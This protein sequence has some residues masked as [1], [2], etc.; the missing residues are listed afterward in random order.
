M[1]EGKGN[2]DENHCILLNQALWAAASDMDVDPNHDQVQ[3]KV[4]VI[5]ERHKSEQNFPPATRLE[6]Y[7]GERK[8]IQS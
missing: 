6:H 7:S 5:E 4:T 1:L 2:K 3:F 8:Q